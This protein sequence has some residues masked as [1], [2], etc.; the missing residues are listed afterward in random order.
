MRTAAM[1]ATD[2]FVLLLFCLALL[3]KRGCV[4]LGSSFKDD[5]LVHWH[6]VGWRLISRGDQGVET[7]NTAGCA[8]FQEWP[9]VLARHERMANETDER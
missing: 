4:N 5:R 9:N 1:D 7:H 8:T 3:C 2:T 6:F